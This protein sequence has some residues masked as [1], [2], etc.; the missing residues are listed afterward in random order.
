MN[1]EWTRWMPLAA[2]AAVAAAAQA[3]PPHVLELANG[4]RWPNWYE[5]NPFRAERE[6]MLKGKPQAA[7]AS[8]AS[9]PVPAPAAQ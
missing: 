6:K 4:D 1:V 5:G 8:K 3:A 7:P 2:A 9:A